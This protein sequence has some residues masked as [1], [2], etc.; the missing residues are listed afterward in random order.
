MRAVLITIGLASLCLWSCQNQQLEIPQDQV[1][2]VLGQYAKENPETAVVLHTDLG[3]V[4]LRLFSETPLHRANFVRMIKAGYYKKSHF[5]RIISSFMVQGGSETKINFKYVVPNEIS[6]DRIH[7][8][9]ALAMAHYDEGN[10][11]N[12]SSPTE[13]YIVRGRRFLNE[14]LDE[15][16]EKYPPDQLKILE[17]LGG[18]PNLDGKYTVF[19]EVTKGMD[20]IEKISE[21]RTYGEDEPEQKIRFSVEL[22]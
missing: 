19:G 3:D 8:Y 6:L 18:A 22:K 17:T 1:A 15:L 20:I 5:Y 7:K 13:F 16:R 21:V 14:D 11:N 10:P 2:T 4:E 9:G 12:N